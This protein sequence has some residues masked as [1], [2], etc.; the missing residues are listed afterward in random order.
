MSIP[1]SYSGPVHRPPSPP[2]DASTFDP[3]TLND[4][5]LR[6]MILD[7][8]LCLVGKK[9]ALEDATSKRD[10]VRRKYTV[11]VSPSVLAL[12]KNPYPG[13][14]QSRPIPDLNRNTPSY[15]PCQ[16]WFGDNPLLRYLTPSKLM[17]LGCINTGTGIFSPIS[18]QFRI[19]HEV[20]ARA[21]RQRTAPGL[22][23]GKH[24][25]IHPIV[26]RNQF[27]LTS[28]Y[29]YECLKPTLRIVTK[30]LDM[31]SVLD[32][33]WSLGQ[34]WTQYMRD[35]FTD[36]FWHQRYLRFGGQAFSGYAAVGPSQQSSGP[37]STTQDASS[38]SELDPAATD[39]SENDRNI[40]MTAGEILRARI[41]TLESQLQAC[42][43][44]IADLK[45]T[46]NAA[47]TFVQGIQKIQEKFKSKK[48]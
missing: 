21:S 44:E 2:F 12:G 30:M 11:E 43:K 27:R 36:E 46:V 8:D 9:P 1:K 33:L 38:T 37:K 28:D 35:F 41:K 45:K 24:D 13:L 14:K 4:D 40:K 17:E 42:Q 47:A 3:S 19:D 34:R 26:R 18:P 16:P 31:D 20:A 39:R 32:M 15:D 10:W 22:Y 23:I 48:A 29:E 6:Q 7:P 25:G 5:D